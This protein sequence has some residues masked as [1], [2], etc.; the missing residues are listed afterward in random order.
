MFLLVQ[1]MT[2]HIY[3]RETLLT[4]K[5]KKKKK[6]REIIYEYDV[7]ELLNTSREQRELLTKYL[8]HKRL[9]LTEQFSHVIKPIG[10]DKQ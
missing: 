5:K 2:P 10:I 1:E 3:W 9:F 7:T 8:I 6:K 4:K